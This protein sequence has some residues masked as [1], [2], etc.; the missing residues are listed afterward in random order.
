M[1]L[2]SIF[3]QPGAQTTGP[4]LLDISQLQDQNKQLQQ[5]IADLTNTVNNAGATA[6]TF[7]KTT[8]ILDNPKQLVYNIGMVKDNYF[9]Y[10]SNHVNKFG[11]Q[12]T[13]APRGNMPTTVSSANELWTKS[14]GHKG[15]ILRHVAPVPIEIQ[16]DLD[17]SSADSTRHATR[18]GFQF[19]Y[20]PTAISLSYAGASDVDPNFLMSSAK[21]FNPVAGA[22]LTQSSM[23]FSIVLNRKPDFKYYDSN[24]HLMS[25]APRDLY[26]PRQP[27]RTEQE[28]IYAKGTM[29]DVE[30]LLGTLVGFQ[31]A[32]QL[33]GTTTD[34]GFL[35]GAPIE[36]HLGKSMRYMGVISN[37]NVSHAF[38]DNRMVPTFSTIDISM[39]RMPDYPGQ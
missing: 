17:G 22:G 32:T 6:P 11:D 13:I 25:G 27:S 1:T 21:K 35:I 31:M 2:P 34:I 16:A 30:F 8:I 29:Y 38:F 33:R 36:V 20:N 15:M 10:P 5:Q 18:Y 3:L 12:S 24:G 9:W 39:S 7:P 28:Q 23:S 4:P 37:I 14:G 26:S 19:H